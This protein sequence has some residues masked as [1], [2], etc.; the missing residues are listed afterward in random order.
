MSV[1]GERSACSRLDAN[2]EVEGAFEDV[3]LSLG[4]A[5]FGAGGVGGGWGDQRLEDEGS[6]VACEAD[7]ADEGGVRAVE[8]VCDAEDSGEEPD[9]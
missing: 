8:A 7:I 5:S 2:A 4:G 3:G 6:L 9:E 1:S